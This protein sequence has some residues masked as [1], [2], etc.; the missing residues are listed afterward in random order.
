MKIEMKVYGALCSTE[1]FVI[2]DV[3]A[4]SS[5]F[6]CQYDADPENAEE[7]GCGN[8]TFEGKAPTAEVL[9]KYKITEAE[10]ALIVAQLESALSF[11]GCG[12]CV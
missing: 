5:D 12:W 10:Y 11:G 3:A 7:Y 8:M 2:N 6:G 9:S 4:D 1:L